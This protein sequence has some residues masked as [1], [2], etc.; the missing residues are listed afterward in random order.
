MNTNDCGEALI[1]PKIIQKI[2]WTKYDEFNMKYWNANSI[3][4]KLYTIENEVNIDS[5]KTIHFVAISE[6]R[7]YPNQTEFYN[8]PNYNSY[9][10]CRNDGYGGV[11][12][13]V[14]ESIESSLVESS[15]EHKINYVIVNI[16]C[17]R[18]C[19]AVVYKKPSVSFPVFSAVLSKILTKTNRILLVGDMNV[20]IQISNIN[21]MQYRTLIESLGCC[22][23]NGSDK[24]FATRINKH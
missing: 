17:I 21:T 4:N 11:A 23:L 24:K 6:T 3:R 18:S 7:I 8:L 20:N 15:E 13:F 12:L 16:P 14:H 9:F 22:L 5:N 2:N 19:I 10:N 1:E